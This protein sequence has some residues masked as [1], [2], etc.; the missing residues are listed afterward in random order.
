[1]QG[2][3]YKFNLIRINNESIAVCSFYVLSIIKNKEAGFNIFR[4]FYYLTILFNMRPS[5]IGK[6]LSVR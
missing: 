2:G 1:M 5:T 6:F 3:K 4:S